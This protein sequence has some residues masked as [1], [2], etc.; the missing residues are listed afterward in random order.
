MFGAGFEECWYTISRV[1]GLELSGDLRFRGPR[2]LRKVRHDRN[3]RPYVMA[4]KVVGHAFE[5]EIRAGRVMLHRAVMTLVLGRELGRDEFVCHRDDDVRNNWSDNLYLG[6]R[7]SN[8]ADSLRNGGRLRGD[9]HPF[10]KILEAQVREI[11][12]ALSRGVRGVDLAHVHGV[13]RS[14][15]S[16]IKHGVRRQSRLARSYETR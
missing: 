2:G 16:R 14:T 7:Q 1:P 13:H 3:G 4:N 11:R 6:D 10:T 8:A 12:F 9:R 15:I 5:R